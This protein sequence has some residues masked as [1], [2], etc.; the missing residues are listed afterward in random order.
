MGTKSRETIYGAWV[1]AAA[2][3]ATEARRIADGFAYPTFEWHPS[4]H[5]GSDERRRLAWFEKSIRLVLVSQRSNLSKRPLVLKRAS[6]WLH[7]MNELPI[8]SEFADVLRKFGKNQKSAR[9]PMGR[10]KR[11]SQNRFLDWAAGC[12]RGHRQAT[13]P[14]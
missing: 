12:K 9:V 2:D 8:D 7:R 10:A 3:R 6:D 14:K 11:A 1:R 4:A 5:N 13:P